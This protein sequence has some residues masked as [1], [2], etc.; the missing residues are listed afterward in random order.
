MDN[1]EFVKMHGA[2][3]DFIMINCLKNKVSISG[4]LT[5]KLCN[6]HKGIGADGI[7]SILPAENNN[8]DFKMRIFNSDGS[9]AEMCGNGIRCFAYYL[10]SQN[11][12]TQKKLNVET[13]AGIIKPEIKSDNN[14]NGL[15]RVNMG[16]P[17]FKAEQI[18]AIVK[19]DTDYIQDYKLQVNGNTFTINC[20]SM[21]NPHS[22][23]FNKKI[24]NLNLRKWG[25][26]I[27]NHPMFPEKTNVEFVQIYDRS[28]INIKVWERGA[29]ITMACG[30]GACA[31]VAAGIKNNLLDSRVKVSL[32]GGDLFIDWSSE[33]IFMTGPAKIVFSGKIDL[34][35][36]QNGQ[37]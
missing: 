30:T 33:D 28:N 7:I 37:F 5:K 32:P 25:K 9:E 6:R 29:G 4:K 35:E 23:I 31:S 10:Y 34:Q 14:K 18:P 20:V 12:T 36:D 26:K 15:V 22:I 1:L 19:D 16:Q 11:I 3:N 8:N 27:E 24:D 21:G 13:K 2:G 17:K